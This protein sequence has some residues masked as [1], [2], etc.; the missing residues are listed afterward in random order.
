MYHEVT[1]V[2]RADYLRFTVSTRAFA[3][4]M[5]WLARTGFTAISVDQLVAA[6]DGRS[7]LPRRP[8]VITFDDGSVDSVRFAPPVLTRHGFT[9]IFY[10]VAGLM[11]QPSEWL[12]REVGFRL[13]LIDWATART[14]HADGFE[15]GSHTMT[16]PRLARIAPDE[17]RE[18][19]VRS[20]EMIEQH[21][22]RPIE[23]L[24]YPFGSH[25][26][27]VLRLARDAGYR[28]ACTTLEARS[29]GEDLLALR[30]IPVYG[31][32]SRLDFVSRLLTA[33]PFRPLVRRLRQRLSPR[34]A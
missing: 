3:W 2:A 23:H 16:H 1:P 28:T 13:P 31:T 5:R 21:I 33:E 11:G 29:Q 24:S 20:R 8:V 18:E 6:R 12:Q 17:A 19:L 7:P 22:A 4:Q 9:A 25:D 30:R 14:L 15:I 34:R 32:D 10:I 26:D 27:Q